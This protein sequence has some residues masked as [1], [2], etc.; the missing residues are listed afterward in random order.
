[1]E[2]NTN[3]VDA[4]INNRADDLSL[5]KVEEFYEFAAKQNIINKRLFNN[6]YLDGNDTK[7]FAADIKLLE[8]TLDVFDVVLSTNPARY[9]KRE[10]LDTF[11]NLQQAETLADEYK[12]LES[13]IIDVSQQALNG[14]YSARHLKNDMLE[15]FT[16]ISPTTKLTRKI[17][18]VGAYLN[19]LERDSYNLTTAEFDKFT[20]V[21]NEMYLLYTNFLGTLKVNREMA[22]EIIITTNF[23]AMLAAGEVGNISTCLAS[24][25]CNRGLTGLY[26]SM[27][28]VGVAYL[29]KQGDNIDNA[30]ARS[31]V[32][33]GEDGF[34]IGEM[35]P[36]YYSAF[37]T[38]LIRIL[39]LGEQQV[40]R[41]FKED[42]F[43]RELLGS[44]STY[45]IYNTSST[46]HTEVEYLCMSCGTVLTTD[47]LQVFNHWNAEGEK[48]FC[49][50][51]LDY[52]EEEEEEEEEW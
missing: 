42:R 38:E 34:A 44:T 27:S 48:I 43:T 32:Y 18:K 39:S 20:S 50:E 7:R 14:Y 49:Q 6:T 46:F 47:D 33:L 21:F 35:Y 10:I 5:S 25:G 31:F 36:R 1:M 15:F 26:A 3:I 22:K 13:L 28:N 4:F 30:I 9:E 17:S 41:R 16:T 2:K 12:A 29:V 45:T 37:K 8:V 11:V 19:S 23:E 40:E 24:D 52:D 51:C